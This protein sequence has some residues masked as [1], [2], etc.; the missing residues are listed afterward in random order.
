MNTVSLS[1]NAFAM[2][3]PME[4]GRTI[5]LAHDQLLVLDNQAGTRVRVLSGGVWL[6][7]QGEPDDQFA[8]AGAEL[9]LG[10]PGRTLL[11]GI[12]P[13]RLELTPPRRAGFNAL[14]QRVVA[15][16]RAAGRRAAQGLALGLSLLISIGLPDLLARALQQSWA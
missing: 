14:V 5:D 3:R 1:A 8:A 13:S 7:E 2:Q 4:Q 9:V 12:G 10:K 15:L 6:T 11:G 16:R